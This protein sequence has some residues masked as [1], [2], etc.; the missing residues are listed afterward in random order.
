MPDFI[1]FGAAKSGTTTFYG[2]LAEHPFVEPCV[3]KDARFG[4]TKEVRFFDYDYYRGRDWYRSHFPLEQSRREFEVHHGRPFS[5]AREARRTS[6]TRMRP[7]EYAR[8]C[9][10]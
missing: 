7:A 6:R 9:P 2:A 4:N 5:R 3:T 1:V 8:C 10:T